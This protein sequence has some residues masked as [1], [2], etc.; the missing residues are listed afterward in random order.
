MTDSVE[1]I[2]HATWKGGGQRK[3]SCKDERSFQTV[4]PTKTR[5]VP[6]VS[7]RRGDPARSATGKGRRMVAIG[8]PVGGSA[9]RID[10]A[11]S[12][13]HGV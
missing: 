3:R 12:R 6:F 10:V 1:T 8:P 4:E 7:T 5:C 9:R 2:R 11:V 13:L